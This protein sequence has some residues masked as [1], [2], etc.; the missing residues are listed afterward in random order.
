MNKNRMIILFPIVF[1]L[2]SLAGCNA[3]HDPDG[4]FGVLLLFLLMTIIFF[5]IFIWLVKKGERSLVT[6]GFFLGMICGLAI[7]FN[8]PIEI[9]YVVLGGLLGMSADWA[10]T[11]KEPTG[12]KTAINSLAIFVAE[13]GDAL[14]NAAKK[15][16]INPSST[17]N[18]SIF[19]WTMMLTILLMLLMAKALN[20]IYTA[21]F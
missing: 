3:G 4:V 19:L 13:T 12:A 18:V 14:R 16:E 1:I 10:A 9:Q 20:P 21:L 7:I 17:R 15:T 5:T 11:F 6:C 8:V 2:M